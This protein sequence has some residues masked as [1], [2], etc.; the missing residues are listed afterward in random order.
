MCKMQ[1]EIT[2]RNNTSEKEGYLYVKCKLNQ[3]WEVIILR[4]TRQAL[5]SRRE[6]IL[7]KYPFLHLLYKD[8]LLSFFSYLNLVCFSS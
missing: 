1:I 5:D 3:H 8:W 7:G 4:K 6:G 2:L